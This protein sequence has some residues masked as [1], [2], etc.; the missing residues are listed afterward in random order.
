VDETREATTVKA[1]VRRNERRHIIVD[2][3]VGGSE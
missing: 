2:G 3:R 1:A